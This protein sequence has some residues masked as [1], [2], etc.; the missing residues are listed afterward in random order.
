MNISLAPLIISCLLQLQVAGRQDPSGVP[1]MVH[2]RGHVTDA[3]SGKPL[4]AELEV[5][6]LDGAVHLAS[7]RSSPQ[8]GSFFI[9]LSLGKQYGIIIKSPAY[10]FYSVNINFPGSRS[11]HEVV[12]QV[13]MQPLI[14]GSITQLRNVFFDNQQKTP[15]AESVAELQ[16]L[17][18]FM[19]EHENL[20]IRI[21][22][23]SARQGKK[24]SRR[25]S[26]QRARQLAAYLQENGI[27]GHRI[28]TRG[29]GPRGPLPPDRENGKA[30]VEVEIIKN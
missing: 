17:V 22:V 2:F 23:Q 10:L 24:G 13:E 14:R 1:P 11:Y 8:T 5:Y 20:R 3:Q 28:S 4:E 15:R 16:E 12:S 27:G 7:F 18:E 26:C 6:E 21:G 25:L 30:R 19:K 29:Y 9:P